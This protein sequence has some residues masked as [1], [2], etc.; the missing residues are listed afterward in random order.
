MKQGK[1]LLIRKKSKD[2]WELPGGTVGS[3]DPEEVAVEKT[4]QQI[5]L[6]PEVIQLFTTLE[7]QEKGTNFEAAIFECSVDD[8]AT[9]SSGESVDEV[10]WFAV[11]GL[12][13]EPIGEDVRKILDEI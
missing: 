4:K 9:F 8:D 5:G 10:K 3:R 1:I 11:K 12:D 7:Y 6:S 2:T 13:K